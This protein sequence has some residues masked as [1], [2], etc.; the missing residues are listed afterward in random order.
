MH[1]CSPNYKVA[2]AQCTCFHL[3]IELHMHNAHVFTLLFHFSTEIIFQEIRQMSGYFGNFPI[4]QAFEKFPE[5]ESIPS[6]FQ[7]NLV[8]F[9]K[10]CEFACFS[11]FYHSII[12]GLIKTLDGGDI[13][14]AILSTMKTKENRTR[15]KRYFL[16][17]YMY[18]V[19]CT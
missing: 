2:H 7:S 16:F 6:D 11:N 12:L 9:P 14:K 17:R 19:R 10:V 18:C 15:K 1:M 3:I 5:Y 8:N 4:N 13:Y